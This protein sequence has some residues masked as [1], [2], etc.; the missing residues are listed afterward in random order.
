MLRAVLNQAQSQILVEERA[1]L[2]K[3]QLILADWEVTVDDQRRLT[4]SLR[5]LDELFLLVVVGEFNSGKSAFINALLGETF[6]AEGATP[7]TDHIQV[8]RH[9][10]DAGGERESAGVILLYHQ[11]AFLREINIVDTPGTNAVIRQHEQLTQGFVP[12]SDMVIFVTSADRP[13]TES[14]RT[15]LEHIRKWGKKVI[16]VLNKIDQLEPE[17]IDK[18]LDYIRHNALSLLGFTPEIFPVSARLAIRAKKSGHPA[19]QKD[20]WQNSRYA[21]VEEYILR[22]LDE[23]GRIRLKLI[24]PIGVSER[25]AAQYRELAR[26]RLNLLSADIKAIDSIE[27][28]LEIY[29]SDM[30]H[31]FRYR[32]ADV[33]KILL[34]IDRKSVV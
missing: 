11:A 16:I 5:Q 26:N 6:L 20:L 34:T 27:G 31:D 28:Q 33:E 32:L 3:L 10:E 29:K 4:E 14:E 15:F 24:N 19:E 9:T 1:A 22:T 8:L 7:T 17:D 12:R 18:I 25:M 23:A 30:Q 21:A 13:F 2:Q